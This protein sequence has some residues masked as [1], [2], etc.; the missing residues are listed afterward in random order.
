MNKRKK[1]KK[2]TK[3]KK[4]ICARKRVEIKHLRI[5]QSV[6]TTCSS[7]AYGTESPLYAM[8]EA[9]M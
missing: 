4:Q 5:L 8:V 1:Q 3:K 9:Q 7:E 6:K 2:K